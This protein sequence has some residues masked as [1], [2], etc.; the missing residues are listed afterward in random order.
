M[1]IRRLVKASI[2]SSDTTGLSRRRLVK[3]RSLS[4]V[5]ILMVSKSAY[6]AAT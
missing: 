3:S 1:T 6:E 5:K 4:Q 2:D